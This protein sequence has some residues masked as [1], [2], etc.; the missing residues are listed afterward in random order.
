[1]TDVETQ[2]A[3]EA[4]DR[5]RR[6]W[7][8]ARWSRRTLL[9]LAAVSAALLV[10]L[11]S[12]DLGPYLRERAEQEATQYLERPMHIGRITA[13]LRPGR[14]VFEDV[15]IEGLTPDAAP[16]LKADRITVSVP[17][18]AMFR[19]QLI[20]EVEMDG[21]ES[22]IES[23]PGNRDSVPKLKP[24]PRE[25]GPRWFN[26][27]TVEH[28][29]GRDGHFR[30]IDHAQPWDV[31]FDTV[32][33][34]FVWAPSLD[35]YVAT[36][37]VRGGEINIL[38]YE[39]MRLDTFAARLMFDGPLL[40]VE[41]LDLLAD[42]MRTH[43]SG[44]MNL[45]QWPVQDFDIESAFD[46]APLKEI[47]FFGQHFTA[48]GQGR[49]TGQFHRY[50]N[51]GYEVHG[52]FT[53]P[54]L[55]VS[56]LEFPDLSGRVVWMPNRL[57]VTG[58]RSAFYGG[59]MRLAYVLDTRGPG[60][61]V[62][63]LLASYEQVDLA[64]FGRTMGWQGLELSS[65]ADGWQAMTWPSGR[66]AEMSGD[67]E[68]RAAAEDGRPL[69]AAQLPSLAVYAPKESPFIRDRPLGPVAVGGTVTYRLTPDRIEVSDGWA[70]TDETY[71]TFRGATGWRD[72][73]NM[74]FRV[75][76]TDWQATD[77]LLAAVLTAFGSKTG[78]VEV[79]GRGVFD[80]TMTRWF[81]RPL[82]VGHFEGDGI[83]SW[84][85]VWGKARGDLSIEN[86]YVTVANSVIGEAPA[87]MVANGKYS[88][89]YPRADGGE[90]FDARI[91][92]EHWPLEDFR[93][94]FELDDWPVVGTAF[95]DLRLYGRYE[96]P[97]GFGLLRVS[98]GSG[99][100]EPFESMTSRLTF[101]GAGLRLDG[102]ELTK[103]TGF[104]RGA[105]YIGWA[106]TDD[107][108]GTYS[109]TFD[110][111]KIPVE[112]LT[113]FTVPD[114]NLT[115]VLNFTM[116]GSGSMEFPRYEWEGRI[117]DLFWGD[118]G[119]GQATAHMVIEEDVVTIDR[120]DVASDRLSIS[121]SGRVAMNDVY[122]AE[123]ALRF[124]ETSVDPYLRFVAP[125]L[126]PYTQAVVS[127]SVRFSGEL[128]NPSKLGVDVSIDRADL[129]LFDYTLSNPQT[130]GGARL[131]L[132][133]VFAEDV[134]TLCGVV[135]LGAPGPCAGS[136]GSFTLTGEGTSLTLGGT[137]N[138]LTSALDVSI[139]GASSLAVLQGVVRD[140]RA[141]GDASIAARVTGTLEAPAYAGSATLTNGRLRH[142]SFPHSLDDIHG[143]VR[144]DATGI[145][146][147]GLRARMG[148]GGRSG[149]GEIV[150]GGSIGLDAFVPGALNVTVR[151]NG[152]DLR[153]PEGFRSIVD[154][155]VSLT[156]TAE[157]A[158]LSG[159]VTVRQARYTRR[160][161]GNAGLLG[162][163]TGGGEAAATGGGLGGSSVP[164]EVPIRFDVELVGQRLLVIDDSDATVVV[165][166]DLRFTGTLDKPVLLGRVDIDRGETEFLGNRYTVGGY[167]EFSNPDRIE[168][169]F[170]IEARTQIRQPSQDYRLDLRFSG[171]FDRFTYELSAD[172]PLSQTD[173]L[174]LI[175]GQSPNLQRSE[176]RALESPQE[177]QNQL[178]S[179]V[180]AQL[181][182]SPIST[183]VGR[184]VERTG[185]VDTFSVTPLLGAD[186]TLQQLNPGARVTVGT[187]IS[188]RVY[189]TYSR[190]F[191]NTSLDFDIL[192][193]EYAQNDRMS[194][195]LSRN[196]DGTF[197]LDFRVR[198]RF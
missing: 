151:G 95:A 19:R 73:V 140:V 37:N 15:L 100:E 74:P 45:D 172:P 80:G 182:A 12:V 177:V 104:V 69:A 190:S 46:T 132:R 161:Q 162:F 183:Q 83:R 145:R 152:L 98:P 136:T 167:V 27:T 6:R 7:I 43:A 59:Q 109:F 107:T 77:R 84:D 49:F 147:D 130:A 28:V 102:A 35:R 113:S 120:L 124:S 114:A 180:V 23:F 13:L 20:I 129:K 17:W 103:S 189:L 47:F 10:S 163:A 86:S 175:L 36:I 38:A 16:F 148:T 164:A 192:L 193:L 66:F 119:I 5:P 39:T 90:E 196:E 75:V 169:F 68:I 141:S 123:I 91:T 173:V 160:L 34:N 87:R 135:P 62:A 96:G 150:F 106:L 116:G 76:S 115:G 127:G 118:E 186:A 181:V 121:G 42:G 31:T 144:F 128:A 198:Y 24:R 179:S 3:P 61:T 26:T 40:R 185:L 122:N 57:E 92:V 72:N 146:L 94:A 58:N 170:D 153:F 159:R 133:M 14:F 60:R 174:S 41:G 134:L 11:F 154:A 63:D 1:V 29:W 81:A 158:L 99:W 111:E 21:W 171:T 2:P 67:G 165:S 197:A 56:G 108:W 131:P 8:A 156:G 126:S 142:F 52:G 22:T 33:A 195:V 155:D 138:R 70:A 112:S 105:A 137:V 85:V 139:S 25:P 54:R 187:R 194:W 101:D 117:A 143:E 188:S 110:G 4:G 88:L 55:T 65:R 79:G 82:I 32:A 178:M 176:L 18:W 51:G 50:R 64:A 9:V 44:V 30:F 78:A 184:V 48:A 97:E 89:G 168:P 93:H 149:G 53:T 166:P 191:D 125:Q 71:L 157:A